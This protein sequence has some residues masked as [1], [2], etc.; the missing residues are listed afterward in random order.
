MI[1]S[2]QTMVMIHKMYFCG[3]QFYESFYVIYILG[4]HLQ[5][6]AATS[7]FDKVCIFKLIP[8]TNITL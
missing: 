3:L 7:A 4:N 8:V 5:S 6:P 2:V 1:S